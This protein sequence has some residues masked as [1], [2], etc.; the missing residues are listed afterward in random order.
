MLSL[1]LREFMGISRRKFILTSAGA[2]A[3]VGVGLSMWEAGELV[4]KTQTLNLPRLPDGFKGLKIAFV[5]DIHH[6]PFTS[7]EYVERMVAQIH[8]AAPDL[9]LLG[10]DYP[11]YKARYVAPVLSVL[12]KLSAPM[13]VFAVRGNHDNLAGAALISRE[14]QKN[15]LHELTNRGVWLKRN[16]SQIFLCGVDDLSTGQPDIELALRGTTANDVALLL[17]HNPDF[18]E[19]LR[20]PRVSFAFCGHTHGGQIHLPLIGSPILPSAFGQKYAYGL[21]R[22]PVVPAYVTRGVGTI[23]PPLRVNCP[24]EIAILTLQAAV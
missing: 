3:A 11:Y 5:A 1:N 24:P 18:L 12:G 15:G 13:G 23:F 4:Q 16:G 22:G 17:C 21:V 6:G 19:N 14:L 10:G 9:I 7:L 2:A 20:D 8:A